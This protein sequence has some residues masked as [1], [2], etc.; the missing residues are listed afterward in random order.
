VTDSRSSSGSFN[1]YLDPAKGEWLDSYEGVPTP[2][3]PEAR[4]VLPGERRLTFG[5]QKALHRTLHALGQLAPGLGL[6][7]C[8]AVAGTFLSGWLGP[9]VFKMDRSP[10]SPILL[11]VLLGL[12]IRNVAGLPVAF[13]EGLRVC[14]RVILRVGVALLGLRLSLA[15]A[16]QIGL[17]A[18]PL[19][20]GCIA[21]GLASVLW[22]GKRLGLPPRLA[23][24]IAVGTGICGVSAIVATAPAIK[25]K[26]EEVSYSVSVIA[27]FGM[28]AMCVYPFLAH[29][30]FEGNP[31]LAGYFLGTA[32]HDTS[33]V[34][35]AGLMYDQLYENP[36]ALE[37]ATTTKL[38]RNL[39]MGAVI[40][41]MAW[42]HYRDKSVRPTDS[43]GK[44]K[45]SQSLPFFVLAFIALVGVRTAGDFYG[46]KNNET[47][48][49]FLTCASQSS[50]YC[51][52]LAMGAVGLGASLSQM[53][54]LGWRP[55]C[56]GFAAALLVGGVSVLLLNLLGRVIAFS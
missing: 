10:V 20:F 55:L 35:G 18:L 8:L 49:A 14:V 51:L 5:W 48:K 28:V 2:A 44:F 50:V 38:L 40:P 41:L 29:L 33:Q 19:V 31:T 26:D 45:W 25:A 16:G 30:I 42:L 15:A 21:V 32:I 3:T 7:V 13:E 54:Q 9:A 53:R 22:L 11:T 4:E 56:L 1:V 37:V 17:H 6:A 47:W 24:L 43:S 39:C 27:L 34:A 52:T 46:L 23:S 36:R 12:L